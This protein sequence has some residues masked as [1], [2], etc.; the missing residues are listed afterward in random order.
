[1][2][3]KGKYVFFLNGEVTNDSTARKRLRD[4]L[5]HYRERIHS[6]SGVVIETN[7]LSDSRSRM[8][9]WIRWSRAQPSTCEAMRSD[10]NECSMHP[11][12]AN[13]TY[14]Y[15]AVFWYFF[16][17]LG[18]QREIQQKGRGANENNKYLSRLSS[19]NFAA[20]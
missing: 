16:F 7:S 6:E 10:F 15:L 8:K 13:M 11:G 19:L 9:A 3:T 12:V 18:R 4:S 5:R 17:I 14:L 1:M 20:T 2:V